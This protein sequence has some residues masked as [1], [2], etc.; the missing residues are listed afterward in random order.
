M[1]ATVAQAAHVRAHKH[2]HTHTKKVTGKHGR[3]QGRNTISFMVWQFN[4]STVRGATN[5]QAYY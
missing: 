5:K 1:K 4:G 3:L 2:T